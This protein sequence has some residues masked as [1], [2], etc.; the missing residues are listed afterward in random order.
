MVCGEVV[1]D[2]RDAER[3]LGRPARRGDVEVAT[4]GLATLG[5]AVSAGDYAS[6]QRFL[7]RTARGIGA[8]FT[9]FDLLL[10]PTLGS[11]PVRHGALQPKPGEERML[12]LFGALNAGGLMKRL[13]AIGEAAATVFDFTPYPPLFNVTGQPAMSVPLW[14]NAEGLPIGVQLAGRFG[15][16]AT[17]FRVAGQLER[18]RPWAGRRPPVHAFDA[19]DVGTASDVSD[20]LA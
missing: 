4:W 11:P 19:S 7:Q 18:A 10:T 6:A 13:G 1:A 15:D 3:R 16:D 17:L 20:A 12:K 2:L 14:W 8:F 9:E 5:A